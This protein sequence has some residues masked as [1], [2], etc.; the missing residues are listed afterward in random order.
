M[1]APDLLARDQAR[2]FEHLHMLGG[3]GEAHRKGFGQLADRGFAKR[4][5]R[6]HPSPRRIGKRVEH[7]I[8]SIINHVVN[9]RLVES[10]CQ[11][12]S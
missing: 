1:R 4:E 11:P 3:A 8:E 2:V 6:Q 7:R 12:I 5:P 10:D 9:Y